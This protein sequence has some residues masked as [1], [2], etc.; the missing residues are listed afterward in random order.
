MSISD[1]MTMLCSWNN[2]L[3]LGHSPKIYI[4]F[5]YNIQGNSHYGFLQLFANNLFL[6]HAKLKIHLKV[7]NPHELGEL[8]RYLASLGGLLSEQGDEF[9]CVSIQLLVELIAQV[10]VVDSVE[11]CK[12]LYMDRIT[13]KCTKMN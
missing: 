13:Q 6:N 4:F 10:N 5:F 1:E 2:H 9:R 8:L 7:I 11:L 12:H 3:T